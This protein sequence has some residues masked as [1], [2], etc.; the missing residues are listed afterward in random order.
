MPPLACPPSSSAANVVTLADPEDVVNSRDSRGMLVLAGKAGILREVALADQ[1]GA[2]GRH[3]FRDRRQVFDRSRVL[4]H[5]DEEDFALGIEWPNIGAAVLFLGRQSPVARGH[6]W[7]VAALSPGLEIAC[8]GGPRVA[9]RGD[10]LPRLGDR[11]HVRPDDAIN[12]G[13][14]HL[15]RDLLARFTSVRRNTHEGRDSGCD[16]PAFRDL[17]PTQHVLRA[18]AERP[19]VV[20]ITLHLEDHGVVTRHRSRA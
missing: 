7:C 11:A 12:A 4:A 3:L 2:D 19:D 18:V 6:R 10:G 8:R 15:L 16:T 1:D 14:E 9:T 5:D 17:A 20:G 13:I